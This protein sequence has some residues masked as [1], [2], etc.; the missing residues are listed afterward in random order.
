MPS[1]EYELLASLARPTPTVVQTNI[2]VIEENE[3][4]S[5]VAD[6]YDYFRANF[7]RP[8]VPGI[9]KCFSSSPALMKQI[10]AMSSTLLFSD[11][12]LGRKHKEMIASYV[13]NLNACAY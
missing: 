11:G 10:M 12:R 4:T 3:A 9:L 6:A 1:P 2:P 7:G 13:S 5:E 8:D